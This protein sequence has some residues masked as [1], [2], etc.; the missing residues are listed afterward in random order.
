MRHA[1]SICWAALVFGVLLKLGH[2]PFASVTLVLSLSSLSILYFMPGTSVLV[3]PEVVSDKLE[4]FAVNMGRTAM[5]M[6]P[7]GALF[8]IQHWP[9]GNTFLMLGA[10]GC[11]AT[12]ALLWYLRGRYPELEGRYTRSMVHLAMNLALVLAT[13]LYSTSA[14]AAESLQ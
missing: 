7:V 6:A 9:N 8:T 5:A 12:L 2:F 4:L 14:N 3:Q 1:I 11:S 13:Y 10:V